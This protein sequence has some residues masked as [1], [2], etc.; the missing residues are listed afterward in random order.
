MSAVK[1]HKLAYPSVNLRNPSESKSNYEYKRSLINKRRVKK[2]NSN[3]AFY[4]AGFKNSVYYEGCI[5]AGTS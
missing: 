4:N 1:L 2:K 5:I 3:V